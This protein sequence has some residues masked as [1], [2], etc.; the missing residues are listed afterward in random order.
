VF[1]PER[2]PFSI[3]IITIIVIIFEVMNSV[4]R[5][6]FLF[7]LPWAHIYIYIFISKNGTYIVVPVLLYAETHFSIFFWDE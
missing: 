2:W 3:I 5:L 1:L 4:M 6:L 7:T